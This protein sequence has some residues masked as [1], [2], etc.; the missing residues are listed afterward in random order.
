MKTFYLKLI[1]AS[2]LVS[3]TSCQNANDG[4]SADVQDKPFKYRVLHWNI[5]SSGNEPQV[6]AKQLNDLGAADLIALSEVDQPQVYVESLSK[7]FI[8]RYSF[9]LGASGQFQNRENQRLFLAY[10]QNRFEAVSHLDMHKYE[11]LKL[12]DGAHASPFVVNLKDKVTNQEIVVVVCHFS[13][14]NSD[15]R[16]TQALALRKWAKTIAKP[17]IAIGSF[18]FDYQIKKQTG[19]TAF[20]EFTKDGIWKWSKPEKLVDTCWLAGEDGKDRYPDTI[21]DFAFTSNFPNDWN[22]SSKIIVR[23]GDFPD[24]DQ[25]SD[26]RPIELLVEKK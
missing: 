3:L 6:I 19:N 15:L 4:P 13:L 1:L 5:E 25:T 11:K 24:D 7:R 14:R 12:N 20:D 23:E 8:K 22:S 9:L 10:N 21:V 26:H 2:L 16:Q 18:N 17:V